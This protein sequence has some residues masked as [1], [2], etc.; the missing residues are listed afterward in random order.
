MNEKIASTDEN[1]A[2]IFS[3]ARKIRD[4]NKVISKDL[5]KISDKDVRESL[6]FSHFNIDSAL[7]RIFLSTEELAREYNVD[8]F[9]EE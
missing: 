4:F 9:N 2:T 3:M 5:E 1:L 6:W 7:K 8:L